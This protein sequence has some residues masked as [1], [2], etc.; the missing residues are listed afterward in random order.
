[1]SLWRSLPRVLKWQRALSKND[2]SVTERSCM[3]I[4][5]FWYQIDAVLIVLSF[6]LTLLLI[7]ELGYRA[8]HKGFSRGITVKSEVVQQGLLTL[9]SLLLAFGV[10][11]AEMRYEERNSILID[12]ATSI[13]TTFLRA[14]LFSN[15]FRMKF[16]NLLM[17][18]LDSRIEWYR[19]NIDPKHAAANR[20]KTLDL[21]NALWNKASTLS[22]DK[23][24]VT[25][26]LLLTS[27]NQ[28]IDLQ[29]KQ[30][31]AFSRRVPR[32]IV[33]LLFLISMMVI[34]LVGFGHGLSGVHHFVF[35]TMMSI[36][37][38][39]TLFVMLDLSRGERGLIRN[40]PRV[41]VELKENLT[42][43]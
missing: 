11:M 33:Y 21:Q 2:E 1:M 42:H 13:G 4:S 23:P 22:H 34:G 39:M 24:T 15:E 12:E 19:V 27:L 17:Q 16:E 43:R 35:T 5:D 18:Y 37:L 29:S 26:S 30:E 41:L 40:N 32:V 36:A 10:S 14:S 8:G 7:A 3:A 20:Q 28:T 38:A 6:F 9:L 25:M 31:F